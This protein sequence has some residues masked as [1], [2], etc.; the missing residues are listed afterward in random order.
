MNQLSKSTIIAVL[1]SSPAF[2]SAQVT[3]FNQAGTGPFDYNAGA[4][5]V[6]GSINGIWDSTLTL[7]ANQTATFG[8][9]T[10]L[11]TGL[12]FLYT[13]NF[14][15]TLRSDGVADRAITLGGDIFV[16]PV[17]NRTI[18]FGSAS[19]NEGLNLDL[20]GDRIFTV[21]T[22]KTLAF[23]NTISGG[24][25]IVSGTSSTAA[26]G[27][28][29]FN[30][31]TGNAATSN[32]R[33]RQNATLQF[34]NSTNG[35]VGA[36][37]AQSVTLESGGK[38]S[39]RGNN[40]N[41]VETI[42]G[43]LTTD[44]G[45][46]RP[47]SSSNNY[48][49]VTLDAGS[50]HTLLSIGSLARV[51]KGTLLVRGDS[52]GVNS[53]AS[54]TAGSSNI[55]ITGAA[56]A[57]IGGDGAAGTT[58]VSIIPWL[59]GG[60][61]TSDNGSTFVTY[62]AANGLR[63]LDVTTEFASSF[64]GNPANNVRLTATSDTAIVGNTTV[65]SLILA[66]SGGSISGS[67]TLTVTS[68]AVLMTRT[69]GASS[70]INVNL[71]FGANEGI[72][73]YARGDVV[74]GAIAGTGGLTVH[75]N[76]NDESLS[77]TNGASTYT[78]NTTIL[79]NAMVAAGFLPHASRTGDVYVYGN[80]QLSTAGFNGTINGLWGNGV[81]AYGNSGASSLEIGDNDAT[82]VFDGAIN[83]NDKLVLRKVGE[84]VLTLGGVNSVAGTTDINAGTLLVNGTFG[85][86]GAVNV[87]AGTLGGAGDGVASGVI[88]GATSIAA[89]AKLAPGSAAGLAGNLTFSNGLN[90]SASSNDTGAYLFNLNAVGSSDKVTLTTGIANALNI[91]T[92][93]AA[94]FAFL[95]GLG[96][97]AG[98]YVLFD[99][100][101]TIAGSIGTAFVDFGGGITGT[102]SI[103]NINN[104]VLLTVVPEPSTS[105]LLAGGLLAGTL[106]RRRRN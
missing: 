53:I 5:W 100:N 77:F 97:G 16:S 43:A 11:E 48:H 55:Q 74:N 17:S 68:G 41:T 33:V 44:G 57:M 21:A 23:W 80:L 65:N 9:D 8:V 39:V 90:L 98:V 66:G 46:A 15:L 14:D 94:D 75:G 88:V 50:A 35:N 101:S 81:V 91:G 12:D 73:G 28:V 30:R 71:D 32:I 92:L 13:G 20:D 82:S 29:R 38:L 3:G 24:D 85:G 62:S 2:L 45:G 47:R 70:N 31:T 36:V 72:I 1:L 4:N 19:A 42:A 67:G 58:T 84:G 69:S 64:G 40:T 105:L 18:T 86:G 89:G 22:S 26:G 7:T 63:P 25:F 10:A 78:G 52:L 93:D 79:S 96:F 37:R 60:S 27:T 87:N 49:S 61:T 104:D 56:P 102:L 99:A 6:G 54:A 103:D 95:T 106:L 34:D 83:T 76:R 59:V 51:A